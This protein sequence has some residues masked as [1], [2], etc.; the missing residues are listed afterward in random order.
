VIGARIH[1]VQRAPVGVI[2][3]GL[4]ALTLATASTLGGVDYLILAALPVLAAVALWWV[5]GGPFD[6]ELRTG[7]LHVAHLRREIPYASLQGLAAQG[8][9][10]REELSKAHFPIFLMHEGGGLEIPGRLNV[11]SH[12]L[13]GFLWSRLSPGGSRDVPGPLRE[14]LSR[15]LEVFGP[16]RVWSYRAR[17]HLRPPLSRRGLA[18]CLAAFVAGILWIVLGA[19]SI[20]GEDRHGWAAAGAAIV[21]LALLGLLLVI[22][23]RQARYP[24]LKRWRD[25]GLI[26]SPPGLALVQGDVSGELRWGEIRRIEAPGSSRFGSSRR[27]GLHIVLAGVRIMIAD[28][29]DRPLRMISERI[30]NH[31]RLP[32]P[33]MPADG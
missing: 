3:F 17:T 13:F 1:S 20:G 9:A 12:E 6:A 27:H 8:V 11:P 23:A 24:R 7:G 19:A 21:L 30:E 16:E 2:A 29:Y 25:S 22:A 14:Y 26:I 10:H 33:S 32:A 4:V 28:I 18:L 5:R 31:L 15:Q